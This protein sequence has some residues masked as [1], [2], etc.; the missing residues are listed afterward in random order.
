MSLNLYGQPSPKLLQGTKPSISDDPS[1]PLQI[2][3]DIARQA[4]LIKKENE[5]K[6]KR[7]MQARKLE[8]EKSR[9]NALRKAGSENQPPNKVQDQG[10][11]LEVQNR[12]DTSRILQ[13]PP[14]KPSSGDQPFVEDSIVLQPREEKDNR[15]RGEY[16][17]IKEKNSEVSQFRQKLEEDRNAALLGFIERRR[18]LLSEESNKKN[19]QHQQPV[20]PED[21][22]RRNQSNFASEVEFPDHPQQRVKQQLQINIVHN[23]KTVQNSPRIIS[24]PS[25]GRGMVKNF[26]KEYNSL[27]STEKENFP[28][29]KISPSVSGSN[30]LSTARG[31]SNTANPQK[32]HENDLVK[33]MYDE[34]NAQLQ[35]ISKFENE[36]RI[37]EETSS[38]DQSIK[39]SEKV[40]N[41]ERSLETETDETP[42]SRSIAGKTKIVSSKHETQQ[43]Y[44]TVT[45]KINLHDEFR[46]SQ[47]FKRNIPGSNRE[48]LT[49][50]ERSVVG[51]QK[52]DSRRRDESEEREFEGHRRRTIN[53]KAQKDIRSNKTS[54]QNSIVSEIHER[55][56]DHTNRRG[57]NIESG[58]KHKSSEKNVRASHSNHH[59]NADSLK[60]SN[61]SQHSQRPLAHSQYIQQQQPPNGYIGPMQ[62]QFNPALHQH[63]PTYLSTHLYPQVSS[64]YPV[65]PFNFGIQANIINP[66]YPLQQSIQY[67]HQGQPYFTSPTAHQFQQV[68]PLQAPQQ[69]QTAPMNQ[70]NYYPNQTNGS[71][72]Y[73]QQDMGLGMPNA[74][75]QI[76]R[77]GINNPYPATYPSQNTGN[78]AVNLQQQPPQNNN[79]AYDSNNSQNLRGRQPNRV[80]A[81]LTTESQVISRKIREQEEFLEKFD[82][83][84]RD[85]TREAKQGANKLRESQ[86]SNKSLNK[87]FSRDRMDDTLSI[88][89]SISKQKRD[90]NKLDPDSEIEKT[91]KML[92]NIVIETADF[93]FRK[94]ISPD[95]LVKS[96]TI[97][98]FANSSIDASF[99]LSD[100]ENGLRRSRRR[101]GDEDRQSLTKSEE[102]KYKKAEAFDI[103]WDGKGSPNKNE[104]LAEAFKKNRKELVERLEQEKH[105]HSKGPTEKSLKSGRKRTREELLRQ[106]REMMEYRGI[107]KR[108][109]RLQ[110]DHEMNGGSNDQLSVWMSQD[111]KT[112]NQKSREPSAELLERLAYG[113]KTKIDRKEML[114][115]TNRNFEQ[116]PEVKRKK[117][118]GRKKEEQQIRKEKVRELDQKIRDATNRSRMI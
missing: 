79:S 44:R 39:L 102:P 96:I 3:D 69:V 81:L 83:I 75:N 51:S 93:E 2:Q 65:D 118:E 71:W 4:Y 95:K 100:R 78:P 104:T 61:V 14:T 52:I 46:L 58:A 13:E 47:N 105:Q 59:P 6:L 62:P 63:Q 60:K 48:F 35:K 91:Q 15:P 37:K 67:P 28:C 30:E 99:S 38:P 76:P 114:E 70:F 31:K 88:E 43:N 57:K 85:K 12:A 103:F 77:T 82:E 32:S 113:K 29:A 80:E 90:L 66:Q 74:Q 11:P 26:T 94:Q 50:D 9:A 84:S 17:S 23:E 16:V 55:T 33:Q 25:A 1:L 64:S 34:I 20:Q 56:A 89:R 101:W 112:N 111:F 5:N 115:L 8:Y 109:V 27:T 10:K 86:C 40:R 42:K 108:E 41:V 72:P 36:R 18:K 21:D 87:W 24:T 45:K 92:S 53:A 22:I 19:V 107:A 7:L 54:L 49:D 73:Q 97:N 106:R 116:L 110:N 68:Y 117:E 98:G